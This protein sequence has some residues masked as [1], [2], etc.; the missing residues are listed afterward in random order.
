MDRYWQGELV[1]SLKRGAYF[2]QGLRGQDSYAGQ[3]FY[4]V[5]ESVQ[6]GVWIG[7]ASNLPYSGGLPTAQEN[8]RSSM[9]LPRRTYLTHIN[10]PATYDLV[11]A[12][13][14][15][16]PVL[17]RD[18]NAKTA[19]GD[20][21][22]YAVDYES[23]VSN[24]VYLEA[25]VTGFAASPSAWFNFTLASRSSGESVTAGYEL[26]GG[27]RTFVLARGNTKGFPDGGYTADMRTDGLADALAGDAWTFSALFD[28]SMLEVFLN[29]GVHAGTANIYP[30][31][32]LTRL[33][34]V[35]S[36]LPADA[37]VSLRVRAVDSAWNPPPPP[38]TCPAKRAS[39]SG[40]VPKSK[41]TA[42]S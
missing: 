8:W 27:A 14:D 23:A 32:P 24:A 38:V 36:G 7:W 42:S 4:N 1:A 6:G 19:T 3:F 28:R 31:E 16:T 15:L 35:T 34:V 26:A 9:T 18:L 33:S 22:A 20:I 29:G 21:T 41:R 39:M 37:K 40:W 13:Y 12:P 30:T 10:D 25:N 17:G 11:L 2:S 5:P